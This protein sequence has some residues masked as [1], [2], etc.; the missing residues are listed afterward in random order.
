MNRKKRIV[1]NLWKV[2]KFFVS[3]DVVVYQELDSVDNPETYSED[4]VVEILSF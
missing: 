1:S 3:E 4:D 2:Y